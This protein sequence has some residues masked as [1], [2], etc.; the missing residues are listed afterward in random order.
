MAPGLFVSDLDNQRMEGFE[1]TLAR[2]GIPLPRERC[3]L[4]DYR[5][6]EAMASALMALPDVTGVFVTADMA[7]I[8]LMHALKKMGANIPHDMSIIG[9]DDIPHSRLV[10]PAL[11]T[12]RQ[13]ITHKAQIAVEILS[14]HL[15]DPSCP[16]ESTI[17]GVTLVCR[18]SVRII[19]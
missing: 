9:F 7:A 4:A 13:D 16:N 10:T 1:N 6:P 12:I 11:T 15:S 17:L 14:R 3:L 2:N 8:E 19:E 18:E 5:Q